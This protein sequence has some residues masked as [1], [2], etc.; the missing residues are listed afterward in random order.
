MEYSR[1]EQLLLQSRH[2]LHVLGTLPSTCLVFLNLT[3]PLRTLKGRLYLLDMMDD[4]GL[5]DYLDLGFYE[6]RLAFAGFNCPFSGLAI[7]TFQV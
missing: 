5:F 1:Q 3:M 7:S 2:N 6:R 4:D